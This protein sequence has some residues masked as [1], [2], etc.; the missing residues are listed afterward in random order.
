[1]SQKVLAIFTNEWSLLHAVCLFLLSPLC[2]H[3]FAPQQDISN[4]IH[5]TVTEIW[6]SSYKFLM[7]GSLLNAKIFLAFLDN[8]KMFNSVNLINFLTTSDKHARQ[9]SID[10]LAT[11]NKNLGKLLD[12]KSQLFSSWC[13]GE[14]FRNW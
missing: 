9:I 13:K 14:V 4:L 1:M 12:L 6:S 11:L 5:P 8:K 7:T 2:H 3:E 10:I